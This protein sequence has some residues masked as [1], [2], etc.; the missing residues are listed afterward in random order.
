MSFFCLSASKS[1]GGKAAISSTFRSSASGEDPP[2]GL[3]GREEHLG[4]LLEL[5]EHELPGALHE[6]GCGDLAPEALA[7]GADGG[8]RVRG[9]GEELGPGDPVAEV[10]DGVAE[11]LAGLLRDEL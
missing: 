7:E 9:D 2:L 10:E 8:A 5:D 6:G 4:H 1:A 11:I 3:G